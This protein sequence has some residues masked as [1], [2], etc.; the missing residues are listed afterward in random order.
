ME[1]T[2]PESYDNARRAIVNDINPT[3]YLAPPAPDELEGYGGA[4]LVWAS[5]PDSREL[6]EALGRARR[7]CSLVI[8]VR[9]CGKGTGTWCDGADAHTRCSS[10]RTHYGKLPPTRGGGMYARVVHY[11]APE[12]RLSLGGPHYLGAERGA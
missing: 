12:D 8:P 2:S 11:W 3:L 9:S 6:E 5:M 1:P 10:T 7:D 4:C